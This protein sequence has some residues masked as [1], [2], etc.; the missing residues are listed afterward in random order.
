MYVLIQDGAVARY[1]YTATDLILAHPEVSWPAGVLRDDVLAEY[2]VLPVV[3]TPQPSHDVATQRAVEGLP[4]RQQVR[5]ADGTFRADD[6]DTLTDEA[7]QWVQTWTVADKTADEIAAELAEWR[8]GMSVTPVQMRLALLRQGLLDDVT[9]FVEA[10]DLE[11]RMTWEY[12]VRIDR[13]NAL[14][15]A[16]AEAIGAT[17]ADVD[18]LFRLAATL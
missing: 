9:A 4:V 15:A 10:A 17:P 18:D 3:P 5:H 14:I 2:G 12:A 6:P 13:D 7:W 1:P 11:T 8:S 16:A